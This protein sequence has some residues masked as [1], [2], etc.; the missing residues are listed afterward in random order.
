MKLNFKSPTK[1][2]LSLGLAFTLCFAF[3]NTTLQAQD[4]KGVAKDSTTVFKF[5]DTQVQI[6]G[7]KEISVK[8]NGDTTRVNVFGTE[9]LVVEGKKGTNVKVGRK[10]GKGVKVEESG[11]GDTVKVNVFGTEITVIE[12]KDGDTDVKIGDINI[13]VDDDDDKKSNKKSS[14]DDDDDGNWDDD[15]DDDDD[16]WDDDDD[17]DDGG[18]WDINVGNGDR[19]L[20]K[21]KTR[22]WLVDLG[23]NPLL[24]NNS[25]DL[26]GEASNLDL[27]IGKSTNVQLH[28]FS[29]RISVIQNVLNLKYG[30]GL[31]FSNYRFTNNINLVPDAASFSDLVQLEN[32]L[33]YN[34][35]KLV[36]TYAN[37]PVMVNIITNPRRP[38]RSFRVSAGVYGGLLLGAHTKQRSNAEGKTKVRDDFNVRQFR[39]GFRGEVGIGVLNFYTNY[40]PVGLFQDD[41]GAPELYPISMGISV[42]PF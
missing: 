16:D 17:D 40:S 37:L 19:K 41:I 31:D 13:G 14:D 3:T 36:T 20:K 33:T 18:N 8:E 38:R 9:V 10:D 26:T 6:K 34:K 12:G 4:D 15:D 22:W 35:N 24:Q 2:L 21:V 39:Y 29:Q 5:G 23:V 30:L 7:D 42:I 32:D 27:N 1:H 25:F 28:V 11:K